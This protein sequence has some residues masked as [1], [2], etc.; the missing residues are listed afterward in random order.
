LVLSHDVNNDTVMD[1]IWDVIS[2]TEIIGINQAYVGESGGAYDSATETTMLHSCDGFAFEA[3]VH[4]YLSKPIEKNR[5][6]VLLMN[7]GNETQELTANFADIPYADCE[8][9]DDGSHC[10]FLVRD[11]WDHVDMGRFRDFWSVSVESHDTAFI[12][13]EKVRGGGG[14]VDKNTNKVVTNS[15]AQF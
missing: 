12:V 4:Q 6:A 9:N 1:A 8:H 3:P 10:D 15:T 2:N 13:L 11:I 5:I 7:S 14:Q